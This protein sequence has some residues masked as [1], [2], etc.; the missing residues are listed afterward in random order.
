[1]TQLVSKCL[2]LSTHLST[3]SRIIVISNNVA[4]WYISGTPGELSRMR[5]TIQSYV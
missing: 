1:M 5:G 4:E 2:Q 3:D